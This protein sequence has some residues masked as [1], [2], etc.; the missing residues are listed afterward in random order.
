MGRSSSDECSVIALYGFAVD[1]SIV[2][3]V[4]ERVVSWFDSLNAP[5]TTL[6]VEGRGF[7]GKVRTFSRLN[8]RLRKRG[9]QDVADFEVSSLGANGG[10]PLRDGPLT[11]SLVLESEYFLAAVRSSLADLTADS[12]RGLARDVIGFLHPAYGVGYRRERAKGPPFYAIGLSMGLQH[13]GPEY[14]E[15]LSICRWGDTGMEERVWREGILRDVY[16]WNFLTQVQ[17]RKRIGR[18]S[19]KRWI[20]EGQRR[21]KLSKFEG[22]M[23]LWELKPGEI[24]SVRPV[25]REAGLIFDY[26]NYLED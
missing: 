18:M 8:A 11:A 10:F 17:L 3:S 12:M 25:L 21:G 22:D 9:F 7:S 20:G 24:R 26:R 5:A 19:L 1:P 14:E 2:E 16:P 23:Y 13:S 6:A 4:Y 15:G